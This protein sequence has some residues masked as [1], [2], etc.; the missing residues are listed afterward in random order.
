MVVNLK[1]GEK[2][3]MGGGEGRV[4][5]R[6]SRRGSI[7]SCLYWHENFGAGIF[8][9]GEGKYSPTCKGSRRMSLSHP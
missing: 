4:K 7:S 9:E 8:A 5:K 3:I 6:E 2:V 1:S